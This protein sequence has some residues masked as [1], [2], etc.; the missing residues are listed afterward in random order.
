MATPNKRKKLKSHLGLFDFLILAGDVSGKLS[1]KELFNEIYNL[2]LYKEVLEVWRGERPESLLNDEYKIS[3]LYCACLCM[4]EQEINWGKESFQRTSYFQTKIRTPNAVR[5]RDMLMGFIKQ[6]VKLGPDNLWWYSEEK[7]GTTTTFSPPT[8]RLKELRLEKSKK[9]GKP[10]NS[11]F[12]DSFHDY[13]RKKYFDDLKNLNGTEAIMTN[14]QIEG[15]ETHKIFR[16]LSK[17]YPK[18]PNF[19]E[20][21]ICITKRKWKQDSCSIS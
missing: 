15:K 18:N 11:T 2:N 17:R 21:E 12:F 19:C 10:F 4:F 9:I 7:G 5:C 14:V 20:C 3:I 6:A 8:E 16:E 13:P 1:H